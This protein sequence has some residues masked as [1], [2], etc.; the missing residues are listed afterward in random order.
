MNKTITATIHWDGITSYS[1]IGTADVV[2]F[3]TQFNVVFYSS[4]PSFPDEYSGTFVLKKVIT[5]QSLR[6]ISKNNSTNQSS[7]Y[8]YSLEGHFWDDKYEFFNGKWTEEKIGGGEKEEYDFE[9]ILN[10]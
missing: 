8:S 6:G 3:E 10:C 5:P 4:Y 9:L 2:A 1:P 7:G